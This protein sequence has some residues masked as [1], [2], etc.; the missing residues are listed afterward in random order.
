MQC[1]LGQLGLPSATANTVHLLPTFG[2]EAKELAL[3]EAEP[4]TSEEAGS[5]SELVALS[6][7]PG[8]R[9]SHTAM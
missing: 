5:N 2:S 3:T 1:F 6:T 4:L 8:L 7:G 9:G